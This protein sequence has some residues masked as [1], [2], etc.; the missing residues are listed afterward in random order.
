M[1][2]QKHEDGRRRK[3]YRK[4]QS[5]CGGTNRRSRKTHEVGGGIEALSLE[6]VETDA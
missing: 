5:G 2:T 6:R 1:R 4:E 3:W